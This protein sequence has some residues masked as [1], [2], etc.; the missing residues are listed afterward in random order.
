MEQGRPLLL[1]L[2]FF[3]SS[4]GQGLFG[5]PSN[6]VAVLELHEGMQS[7]YYERSRQILIAGHSRLVALHEL[8][9]VLGLG[10][11][12]D[13]ECV[14]YPVVSADLCESEQ[15]YAQ[16]NAWQRWVLY[17]EAPLLVEIEWAAGRWNRA[18]GEAIFEVVPLE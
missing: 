7:R 12:D 16:V 3:L 8:G 9:H 11:S 4:C 15:A 5:A 18:A 13:R 10:H 14:M 17:V 6:E 2:C 1:A